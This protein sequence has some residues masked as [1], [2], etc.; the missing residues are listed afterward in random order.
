VRT[1]YSASAAIGLA[2][3]EYIRRRRVEAAAARLRSSDVSVSD[4][5][6]SVGFADIT[7]FTRCF[8]RQQGVTPSQRRLAGR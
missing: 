1:V 8:K 7:T 2:P 6:I 3:A 5:A 4:V